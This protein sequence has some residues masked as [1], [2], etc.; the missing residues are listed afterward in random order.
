MSET[1]S[2]QLDDIDKK[3]INALQKGFPISARP[4]L[5]AATDLGLSE[6]E[7]IDRIQ[8]LLKQKF[9]TRFGPMYDAAELGG[10]LTLAAMSVP[11][12]QFESVSAY[13]NSIKQVAHNY[14]REHRLNMWFV[15]A[16][17]QQGDIEKVIHQIEN[18]TRLPVYNMPKEHSFFVNLYLPA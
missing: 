4:Y 18:Q 1:D 14:E 6:Q 17:E 9:L 3:I 15:L 16:T 7:L 13:L 11:E 10:G 12:N 5:E 8:R 2:Y